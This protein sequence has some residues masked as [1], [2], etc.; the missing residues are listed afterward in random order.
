VAGFGSGFAQTYGAMQQI[1][2]QRDELEQ[3]KKEADLR[4]KLID[5]QMQKL[6][7]EFQSGD[8]LR[9]ALSE[10]Q[11][12][13]SAIDQYAGNVEDYV[14][15][16]GANATGLSP[17][18]YAQAPAELLTPPANVPY[19]PERPAGLRERMIGALAMSDPKAALTAYMSPEG[20]YLNT[21][22]GL[23]EI[24]STGEIKYH[25]GPQD[26]L[27]TAFAQQ[28]MGGGGGQAQQ[29]TTARPTTP[30]ATGEAP[31]EPAPAPP[32]KAGGGQAPTGLSYKMTVDSTGKRSITAEPS[33][34]QI[35]YEE[36]Y[37]PGFGPV[38]IPRS[39]NTTS[40]ERT[41][42]GPPVQAPP[43]QELQTAMA[44]ALGSGVPPA[45]LGQAAA[46]YLRAKNKTGDPGTIALED[47]ERDWIQNKGAGKPTPAG[48]GT[49]A[50]P[51]ASPGLGPLTDRA[52]K[53][54]ADRKAAVTRAEEQARREEAPLTEQDRQKL[55]DHD[56]ILGA[57]GQLRTFTPE[58]IQ[59]YS[60]VLNRPL[61]DIR[62]GLSSVLG[63]QV[64]ERFTKFR[65][66]MGILKGTAFGEGGKQLTPFESSV[67]F[68]YTPTGKEL[69][70]ATEIASKI[71]YLEA[72][73]K[74]ARQTRLDLA[75]S[76]KK[77]ISLD[78]LDGYIKAAMQASGLPM[79]NL[80]PLKAGT[81]GATPQKGEPV[82]DYDPKT[83][84]VKPAR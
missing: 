1:K 54:E 50:I 82:F 72:F 36:E 43:S 15:G 24:T 65:A 10:Q 23:A 2:M 34:L 7:R 21:P 78:Q 84:T 49:P 80:Q 9:S 35:H 59:A 27:F 40:G 5:M 14:R 3:R 41:D 18:Q 25:V 39:F 22:Q 66:L 83:K 37:I 64:D 38:R 31:A 67:V 16:T 19:T 17:E 4:G 53:L 32:S 60:G 76:G 79:P 68:S 73:T 62:M 29:P 20:K 81:K 75:R 8:L 47:W 71:Q 26:P 57:I 56:K 45:K 46:E 48:G 28:M 30:S 52:V 55:A 69:G 33:N 70:G 74:L 44:I 6:T 61:A 11:V 58:E 13:Q 63:F 42:L 77:D 12:P 51:G